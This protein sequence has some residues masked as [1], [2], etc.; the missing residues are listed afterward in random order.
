VRVSYSVTTTPLTAP[1]KSGEVIPEGVELDVVEPKSIDGN[2]RDMMEG[3]YDVGEM[4]IVT[5]LKAVDEGAPQ[6]AIPV[7]TSG[8]RFLHAGVRVAKGLEGSSPSDWRGRTFGVVRFWMSSCVWHRVLLGEMYGLAPTDV[9]WLSVR[10]ETIRD[11]PIPQG[12]ELSRDDDGRRP[13]QL[14]ADGAVDVF[15]TPGAGEQSRDL[16][17]VTAPGFAD[18]VGAEREYYQRF[19]ILPIL[20]VTAI[21]REV[22]EQHPEVVASLLDAYAAAK[23]V[24]LARQGDEGWPL[25]TAGHTMSQL[26]TLVGGDPWP[27]GLDENRKAIER[28][29]RSAFDEGLLTRVPDLDELFVGGV[30]S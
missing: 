29:A 2:S 26:G 25:P 8:R 9:R 28:L 1:I 30:G 22:Y 15:L 3:R 4:S 6:V 21:R 24:C 18:C 13:A 20:H 14:V 10:P 27:Y 17:E 5:F 12:V 7:F 23:D 19:G 16:D 11:A